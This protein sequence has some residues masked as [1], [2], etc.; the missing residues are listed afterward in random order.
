MA[1]RGGGAAPALP[2]RHQPAVLRDPVSGLAAVGWG[3]ASGSLP[4]WPGDDG[5]AWLNRWLFAGE[6][7]AI[8]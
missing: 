1:R 4:W 5:L 8:D 2:L 6:R 3:P 7:R